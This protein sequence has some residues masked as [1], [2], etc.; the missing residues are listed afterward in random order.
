MLY[1]K[2]LHKRVRR[3]H[4]ACLADGNKLRL[5]L[6]VEFRFGGV[7]FDGYVV[8]HDRWQVEHV[9][10]FHMV[11]RRGDL[12][13]GLVEVAEADDELL[14]PVAQDSVVSLM[15]RVGVVPRHERVLDRSPDRPGI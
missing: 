15:D 8:I 11:R 12:G 13:V 6:A 2:Q 10:A 5:D 1:P 3:R 4:R 7:Q 14:C 9:A